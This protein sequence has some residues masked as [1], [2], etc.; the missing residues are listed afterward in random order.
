MRTNVKIIDPAEPRVFRYSLDWRFWLPVSDPA[1]I[2]VAFEPDP[3]FSETLCHIGIPVSNQLCDPGL[4]ADRRSAMQA[5][6]FPFGLP[7][8]WVSARPRDQIR[9][10][11]SVREQIGPG[12]YFMLGFGNSRALRFDAAYHASTSAR[13]ADRLNQA[14]FKAI[15]V[16]GAMPDLRVPEYIFELDA[17]SVRFV[18][19]HRFRRKSVLLNMLKILMRTVGLIH[20]SGFLPCYYVLAST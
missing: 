1:K 5:F 9:F 7:V 18:L 13:A 16:L 15:R 2:Q 14:G 3:D 12:G 10:Y 17:R 19:L 6:V 8:R 20:M 4:T 11:R